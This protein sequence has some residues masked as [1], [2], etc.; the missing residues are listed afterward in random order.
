M[1][2]CI[3]KAVTD[4]QIREAVRQGCRTRKEIVR[5]LNVGQDCGKCRSDLRSLLHDL[6]AAVPPQRRMPAPRLGRV[7]ADP[8]SVSL[9]P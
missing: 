6:D 5:C 4:G 7:G 9:H 3:C 1:Y 2:V 8:T